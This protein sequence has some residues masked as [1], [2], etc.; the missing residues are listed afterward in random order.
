MCEFHQDFHLNVIF[1][2]KRSHSSEHKWLFRLFIMCTLVEAHSRLIYVNPHQPGKCTKG[3]YTP[4]HTDRVR[5][6][7]L[8][9]AMT[10]LSIGFDLI[11]AAHSKWLWYDDDSNDDYL[12]FCFTIFDEIQLSEAKWANLNEVAQC[13]VFLFG[14]ILSARQAWE[15]LLLEWIMKWAVNTNK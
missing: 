3:I 7:W 8:I 14:C 4:H 9:I 1:I 15:N 13:F 12:I 11:D 10:D 5:Y 2:W 6:S